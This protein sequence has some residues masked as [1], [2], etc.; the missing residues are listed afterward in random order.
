MVSALVSGSSGPDR[1]LARDNVLFASARQFTLSVS[2]HSGEQM[3]TG[4]FNVGG[5]RA[6]LRP[7]RPL[8]SY[9]LNLPNRRGVGVKCEKRGLILGWRQILSPGQ[10]SSRLHYSCSTLSF[11]V[12]HF[13]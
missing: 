7:N 9:R 10:G 6:K 11:T 4:D 2:L 12:L 3:G 8:G 1:A 5:N 13:V